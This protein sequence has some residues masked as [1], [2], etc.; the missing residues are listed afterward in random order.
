MIVINGISNSVSG[1]AKKGEKERR[2]EREEER[3]KTRQDRPFR[4][5]LKTLPGLP[6]SQAVPGSAT[7]QS[8]EEGVVLCACDVEMTS[9]RRKREERLKSRD[10]EEGDM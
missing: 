9:A 10:A 8:R 7:L 1:I 4:S 5:A 6:S 2:R 3:R